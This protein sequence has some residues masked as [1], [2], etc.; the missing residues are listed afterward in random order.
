MTVQPGL[1]PLG[2]WFFH[3]HIQGYEDVNH[4]GAQIGAS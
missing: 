2:R 3:E 4:Q 1:G